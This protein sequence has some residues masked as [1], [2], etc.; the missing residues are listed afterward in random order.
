MDL[1]RYASAYYVV[2]YILETVVSTGMLH[3]RVPIHGL[4]TSHDVTRHTKG[5]ATGHRVARASRLIS[6]TDA[7]HG[8]AGWHPS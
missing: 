2:D 3:A 8:F 5:F 7:G 4:G 1:P 6:F